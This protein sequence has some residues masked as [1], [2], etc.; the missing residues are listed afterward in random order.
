MA[1]NF[2]MYLTWHCLH[3]FCEDFG[4]YL[5]NYM[6]IWLGDVRRRN[7][8]EFST[9]FLINFLLELVLKKIKKNKYVFFLNMLD[10]SYEAIK[11][12]QADRTYKNI[13]LVNGRGRFLIEICKKIKD[14]H[15]IKTWKKRMESF[16]EEKWY[17]N[18][19]SSEYTFW[20]GCYMTTA[21]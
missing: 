20:D 3:I 12:G 1:A 17:K 4:Q 10:F 13:N 19:L 21:V 2:D 15:T 18:I 14:I 6:N 11:K 16:C 9:Y 7:Y 8:L 5:I